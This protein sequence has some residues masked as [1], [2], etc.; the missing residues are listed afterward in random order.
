MSG[1]QWWC[2]AQN[3]AWSWAW[4]P[5]PGVWLIVLAIA[6]AYVRMLRGLQRPPAPAGRRRRRCRAMAFAAGL[7]TLWLALDWPLGPLG[8]GYLASVH[9]LQYLLIALVAP[10]LLLLGIPN[11]AYGRL[12]GRRRVVR[13]LRIITHPL[14]ALAIF[15]LI[16]AWTHLPSV[17]DS[18]MRTQGGSFLIDMLW[19]AAGTV[20]WWPV[21]APVPQRPRFGYGLKMGYLFLATVL[22]TM[23]YAFLTFGE[24][25]FYGIYELA[26]RATGISARQDQ[27]IAGL[28]M[29]VGGGAILWTA[30][31][32]LFFRWWRTEGDTQESPMPA[33][34]PPTV[35][36]SEGRG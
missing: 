4:Q 25:P 13:A 7:C 32:I 31:T 11:Q 9:M 35:A 1:F 15:N 17:V 34:Q 22:N 10:A 6:A 3:T 8:A 26:P 30:I 24:L 36:N 16:L 23:P 29:K 14:A 12:S 2:S 5:Y 18:L 33:A 19:L 28:L 27:Q 21:I 20:F